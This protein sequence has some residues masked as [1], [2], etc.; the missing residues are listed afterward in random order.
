MAISASASFESESRKN[1]IFTL[2]K[3]LR[4]LGLLRG[5]AANNDDIEA[6]L[7]VLNKI[8]FSQNAKMT[9]S[10]FDVDSQT[11]CLVESETQYLRNEDDPAKDRLDDVLSYWHNQPLMRQNTLASC[12]KTILHI[13]ARR[14]P[15]A[16]DENG[17]P[18]MMPDQIVLNGAKLYQGT[19][20]GGQQD[21]S[22]PEDRRTIDRVIELSKR[23]KED[24]NNKE[25]VENMGK[26]LSGGKQQ[27]ESVFKALTGSELTLVGLN[28]VE[29]G[30]SIKS[31]HRPF[32]EIAGNE[33]DDVVFHMRDVAQLKALMGHNV[34]TVETEQSLTDK[35]H[36]SA[37][38][39]ESGMRFVT[40][41]AYTFDEQTKCH[42][43]KIN[44]RPE[45]VPE[46]MI[47]PADLNVV[48]ITF[49]EDT[50][51][52]FRLESASFAEGLK[53]NHSDKRNICGFYMKSMQYLAQR[54]FPPYSS[55]A[56]HHEL[57]DDMNELGPAP[58]FESGG[59]VKYIPF[60]GQ[61]FEGRSPELFNGGIG[62]G[63]MFLNR[64]MKT[65]KTVGGKI[66]QQLSECAVLVDFPL[67]A[68]PADSEW[69][70]MNIDVHRYK[71]ALMEGIIPFSHK[72]FDH[73]SAEYQA[74]QIDGKG[75]GFFKGM[76]F[77]LKERDYD[78]MVDKFQK[79]GVPKDQWPDSIVYDR[80]GVVESND[81]LFK[82]DEN[83]YAYRVR[84][85]E[86]DVRFWVEV[87]RNGSDH[88]ALTDIFRIT[89]CQ[90]DDVYHP[91]HLIY[92]DGRG[93]KKHGRQFIMKTQMCLADISG[94][95]VSLDKLEKSVEGMGGSAVVYYDTTGITSAGYAPRPDQFANTFG[96]LVKLFPEK[97]IVR[98]GYCTNDQERQAVYE[99]C[100][101]K[102]TL[103]NVT[104]VGAAAVFGATASNKHGANPDLDLREVTINAD[105][106]SQ[107][108]YDIARQ[109]IDEYVAAQVAE[110]K[111][112]AKKIQT[113][114]GGALRDIEK[115]VRSENY[116][117]QVFKYIQNQVEKSKNDK[118]EIIFDT[119]FSANENIYDDIATGILGLTIEKTHDDQTSSMPKV[120]ANAIKELKKERELELTAKN[121]EPA[122]D[123]EFWMLRRLDIDGRV[124]FRNRCSNN[125]YAMHIAIDNEQD[126]AS[127]HAGKD[128]A[129]AQSWK[130]NPGSV[131]IDSTGPTGEMMAT[132]ASFARGESQFDRVQIDPEGKPT[133]YK[134]TP[135]DIVFFVTQLGSQGEEAQ[136]AQDR[137]MRGCADRGATVVCAIKNGFKIYNP[138]EKRAELLQGFK[139][140]GW[141][142]RSNNA[143]GSMIV[144]DQPF[145]LHGH[146][147]YN[148]M[149][150]MVTGYFDEDSEWFKMPAITSEC[151]H[152][153][154]FEH[155]QRGKDIIH[156]AGERTTIT[157]P[158]NHKA[159]ELKPDKESGLMGMMLTN[160]LTPSWWL[161]KVRRAFK[162]QHGGKVDLL[163]VFVLRSEGSVSD[164][165]NTRETLDNYHGRHVAN[166]AWNGWNN[167]KNG[168]SARQR[169][170]GP[171][172]VD[173][174]TPDTRP[175]SMS[176][177]GAAR[178]GI[179][180]ERYNERQHEQRVGLD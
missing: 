142:C 108:A 66:K 164:G 97:A 140:L 18:V 38:N 47:A 57:L 76:R 90:N 125:E 56:A 101:K 112:K 28:N 144:E 107:S 159:H 79:L 145:H 111:S 3:W 41:G 128:S 20:T 36:E 130:N 104:A 95:G 16:E 178:A 151:I 136:L 44:I 70:G 113:R 105:Q 135:D 68:A 165:M 13:R 160:I 180:A 118:P 21:S 86:G 131:L 176:V 58:S 74:L 132:M 157:E 99:V 109:A 61:D 72:H 40:G 2:H 84:D 143:D 155:W 110:I 87:C 148:D 133:G 120:V 114:E 167:A 5:V 103:R 153:P 175:F 161:I 65:I 93:I 6:Q 150:D 129:M 81:D 124:A 82:I 174:Q 34:N 63:N 123:V 138:K 46:D 172:L 116:N 177:S 170:V 7:D 69:D 31:L 75:D 26:T 162:L 30:F 171:S 43:F 92:N 19:T 4:N 117:Y 168:E 163:R 25:P 55:I 23:A 152:N 149:R 147:F 49:I 42:N 98:V 121:I 1:S 122:S 80:E 37:V 27:N 14:D 52:V 45:D 106:L 51:G 173:M 83:H 126:I 32:L 29:G 54:K 33:G 96:E 73:L 64:A 77:L 91:A 53:G 169:D 59:Q 179:Q 89:P 78:Y 22:L 158:G 9:Q 62:G 146:G 8:D 39:M 60:N 10:A 50:P 166:V 71:Q 141:N 48:D 94:A 17:M 11:F 137:L 154:S 134:L 15:R 100:A 35:W 24:L 119:F 88:S 115:Q 127:L 67:I 85:A 139:T 156:A 102:D 12:Q